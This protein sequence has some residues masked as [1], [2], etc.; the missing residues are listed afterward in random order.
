MTPRVPAGWD[1]TAIP[2]VLRRRL[3]SHP[4]ERGSFTELWRSGWTAELDAGSGGGP[5]HARPRQANLSRSAP[6][7]LR[8]LHLHRRQADLWAIVDGSP[9]VALVDVRPMLEGAGE[10]R[11]MAFQAAPGDLLWLPAGVA[12][13]FLARD[14]LLLVYLVTNEHDGSDEL[15]FR[16]DDPLAGVPWPVRDPIVSP[17]DAT[18]P[19][20]TELVARLRAEDGAS[21]AQPPAR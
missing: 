21:A 3:T 1:E 9:F 5:E 16:W 11:T 7:V 6:G 10:P 19:S 12:H 15:G 8:G 13:G 17:R 4:D 20:L 14:P 18:A 2:G